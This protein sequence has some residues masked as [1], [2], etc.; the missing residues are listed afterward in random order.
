MTPA[1]LARAPFSP[2][3]KKKVVSDEVPPYIQKAV[4]KNKR[5]KENFEKLTPS[6]RRLYIRWID[7]AKK[8]ETRQRRLAE[9]LDRVKRGEKPGMK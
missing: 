6:Q 9:A 2:P 1:G 7:S 8:E 3:A 4:G 5:V